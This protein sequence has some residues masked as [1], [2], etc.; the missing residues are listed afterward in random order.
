M[1]STDDV[2]SSGLLSDKDELGTSDVESRMRDDCVRIPL[3]TEFTD[4]EKDVAEA[5]PLEESLPETE[6]VTEAEEPV[7]G[8]DGK[9]MITKL[10]PLPVTDAEFELVIEPESELAPDAEVMEAEE[11]LWTLDAD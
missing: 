10:E 9:E 3:N 7:D 8:P 2:G 5:E 4:S 6:E 11:P 1:T